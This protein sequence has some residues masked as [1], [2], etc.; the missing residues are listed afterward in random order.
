[1]S[2]FSASISRTSSLIW[3]RTHTCRATLQVKV[4]AAHL[5]ASDRLGRFFRLIVAMALISGE[6]VRM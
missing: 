3:K 5:W 2:A 4:W 6:L 1:M